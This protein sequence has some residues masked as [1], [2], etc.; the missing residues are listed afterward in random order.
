VKAVTIFT[1]SQQRRSREDERGEKQ[2]VIVAAEN[3]FQSVPGEGLNDGRS[4]RVDRR[5]N[6]GGWHTDRERHHV[7]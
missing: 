5:I 7:M 3:V 4:A 6:I 1:R 2:E